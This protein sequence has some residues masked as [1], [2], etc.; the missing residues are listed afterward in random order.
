MTKDVGAEQGYAALAR[1]ALL[2]DRVDTL[3]HKAKAQP[4]AAE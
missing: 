2:G 3:T 1:R 4:V